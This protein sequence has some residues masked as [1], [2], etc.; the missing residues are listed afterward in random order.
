MKL[1]TGVQSFER[2]RNEKLFFVD[3]TSFIKEWWERK[4]N[5]T[6]IT[7]PR[8]FGKTLNMSMLDCFFSVQY[9]NRSDLFEGLSI[10]KEEEY[11]QLQGTYPV[12]NLS[13]ADI[14][15]T[16]F[17]EARLSIC[18]VL[19]DIYNDLDTYLKNANLS[20][21]DAG[22]INQ[23]TREMSDDV[24]KRSLKKL[25]SFLEKIENKNVIILL[26]EYDT[27]LIEAYTHG[28]WKEMTEFM[29]GFFNASFKSNP[30]L[31][32]GIMTGITR[33]SKESMFSDLNN[34]K[35]CTTT[36]KEY[37]T[38]FGFSE[39]EVFAAMD[40]YGYSHQKEEVKRW[41]DGFIFGNQ[42]DMYN[43][44]S[45]IQFLSVGDF[46]NYWVNTSSNALVNHLMKT[47]SKNIKMELEML[48]K[49]QTILVDVEEEVVYNQLDN[50]PKAI[51]GLLVASGY[52]K[53]V[54][55]HAEEDY[56]GHRH[57][58]YELC[59]T[60]E[61]VYQMF[62][63]FVEGWFHTDE[64]GDVYNAFLESLLEHDLDSMN[65]YLNEVSL[66][67]FSTFDTGTHPSERTKPE[68]FY[69]GFILGLMMDLQKDYEITS[70]RESGLGRY[71]VMMEPRDLT[72]DAFI[73]EFKV[74]RPSKEKSLED[75]V[76]AALQQIEE[77]KY[78]TSLL[79]K[80]IPKE[81]IYCYGFAFE[82]KKVLIGE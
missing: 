75:T 64:I 30:S 77:K 16:T 53:V 81:N 5:I 60:N 54:N 62:E 3:K 33:I 44:W 21:K 22:F 12:I 43:P 59:I 52:L 34:L 29:R 31:Y 20:E 38:C 4:D 65:E 9:A 39:K 28:Y 15:A 45:I 23:V 36:S 41:Y 51:W 82:G 68:N 1:A 58:K 2:I 14:K 13:F 24:A 56:R 19:S 57:I 67:V 55:I 70:N 74:L 35:V 18:Q 17:E 78:V 80:G 10:W 79:E 37:A 25:S 71:D 26:D 27:P 61:E 40:M 76:Q 7:R 48:I 63:E 50:N 8:R 73:F 6:L 11:R 47:G 72:K 49:E 32:R 66:S 46:K 69:H 42:K